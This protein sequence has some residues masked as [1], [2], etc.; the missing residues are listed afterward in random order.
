MI[1]AIKIFDTSKD[2]RSMEQS[3]NEWLSENAHIQVISTNIV[4]DE[5][6]LLYSI[7]YSTDNIETTGS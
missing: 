5:S 4:W 7:L 1:K 2:E 3:I 6:N